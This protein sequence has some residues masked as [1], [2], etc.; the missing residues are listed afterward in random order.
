[1]TT[2]MLFPVAVRRKAGG[3]FERVDRRSAVV[4]TMWIGNDD[5]VPEGWSLVGESPSHHA[6]HGRMVT[7]QVPAEASV[8]G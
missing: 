1:M 3:G 6:A 5:P 2:E 8:R 4:E 7:R